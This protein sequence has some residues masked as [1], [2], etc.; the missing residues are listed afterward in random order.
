[1]VRFQDFIPVQVI[2]KFDKVSIKKSQLPGRKS[3]KIC[4]CA[5]YAPNHLLATKYV[6]LKV[7]KPEKGT[8]LL[9]SKEIPWNF[10]SFISRSETLKENREI[11]KVQQ[12]R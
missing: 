12:G 9:F 6:I 10:P 1:M 8:V 2:D 5:Q 7:A 11:A 4:V 3:T